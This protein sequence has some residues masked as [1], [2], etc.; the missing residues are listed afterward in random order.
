MSVKPK[1]FNSY[2][3]NLPIGAV[4]SAAYSTGTH[5]RQLTDK[6]SGQLEFSNLNFKGQ[7]DTYYIDCQKQIQC[8]ANEVH[9]LGDTLEE[10]IHNYP[11]LFI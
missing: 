6:Q 8:S 1:D 5:I 9:H 4:H 11:H 7:T 3:S 2:F 10:A